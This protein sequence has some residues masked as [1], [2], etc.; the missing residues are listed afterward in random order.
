[1]K[2]SIKELNILLKTNLYYHTNT[3][4]AFVNLFK[5][6]NYIDFNTM[7]NFLFK[8]NG[9]ENTISDD[10]EGNNQEFKWYNN[11][12]FIEALVNTPECEL[13][14]KPLYNYKIN[15]IEYKTKKSF[16]EAIDNILED[17]VSKLK[18]NKRKILQRDN[19][20]WF[21]N[22][23]ENNMYCIF[24]PDNSQMLTYDNEN[25]CDDSINKYI[26]IFKNKRK[27]N[28]LKNSFQKI[29]IEEG[30]LKIKAWKKY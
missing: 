11:V 24:L 1:M 9:E 5:G 12:E 4:K 16:L 10:W 14:Y 28:I 6:G 25:D 21:D 26:Q 23:V 19:Y 7:K 17:Y 3:G 18:F 15:D 2:I 8:R 22:A 30:D 29:Q 13:I 20:L 27:E